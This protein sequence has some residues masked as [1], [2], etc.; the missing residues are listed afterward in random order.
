MLGG[1]HKNSIPGMV[2]AALNDIVRP[3]SIIIYALQSKISVCEHDQGSIKEVTVF[4]I[5]I[6]ELGKDV[7]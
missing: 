4:K 3:L 6:V 2:Q 1:Q 7:D 5:V